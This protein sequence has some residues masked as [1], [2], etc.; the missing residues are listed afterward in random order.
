MSAGRPRA[1]IEQ[2]KLHGIEKASSNH[3]TYTRLDMS[4]TLIKGELSPPNHYSARTK[5]A[6]NRVIPNIQ[7]L[8][9]LTEQDL[10]SLIAGF[11]AF[12]EMV[13][14]QKAIR[15]FDKEHPHLAVEDI[16]HR[17]ALSQWMLQSMDSANRVFARFG[18]MPTERTRLNLVGEK[19]QK[20]EDPL[21]VVLGK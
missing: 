14:A 7:N 2:L 21:D 15:E 10:N 11:D 1:T 6:W 5:Q 20:E 18:L 3:K 4:D 13:K 16:K 8:N 12:E 19:E 9:I 17:K